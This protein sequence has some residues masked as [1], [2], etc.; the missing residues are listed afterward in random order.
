[1][2]HEYQT[3]VREITTPTLP[4]FVSACLNLIS[5]KQSSKAPDVPLS[6]EE[7]VSR[8]FAIL[9]PRH[10]TIFRPFVSQLR[11]VTRS[12]VAPTMSDD[13]FVSTSLKES[14]RRLVV[15]LHLT[16]AKNAGGEEWSKDVR[17]LVRD[18]HLTADC[19]FRAVIEDWESTA[20]YV[21][22]PV[23]LGLNGGG[24][25]NEDL[26]PWAGIY[27]G[28]ERLVGLLE[29]L[30]EYFRGGTSAPVTISLGRIMDMIT[31]LLSI[32]I[33][34]S[35]D[36]PSS[37]RGIRLNPAIDREERDGLWSGMPQIYVAAL[38][39]IG[40]IAERLEENFV[41]LA[42]SSFDQLV[43]VFPFGRHSPEFRLAAYDVAAKVLLR[44]GH[45][46][47]RGH[48]GKLALI[49]RSCCQDLVAVDPDFK[50]V[51]TTNVT[52][53]EGHGK[54]ISSNHN[55][56]SFLR[57]TVGIVTEVS[58]V[59]ENLVYGARELLPLF[60]SH[61]PQQFLDIS[62][63][64]LVERTAILSHNKNAM[65]ASILNPFVG[66]NGRAV[67]SILPHLTREFGGDDIVEIFLRPRMPLLR[68]TVTRFPLNDAVNS[69][70]V[71]DEYT[72]HHLEQVTIPDEITP[73]ITCSHQ[74]A[75][76]EQSRLGPA[77]TVPSSY[78]QPDQPIFGTY[79]PPLSIS[80][81]GDRSLGDGE[82]SVDH[83]LSLNTN[84]D[85]AMLEGDESSDDES[86]HLTMQLDTESDSDGE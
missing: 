76:P 4:T 27:A 24:K 64:S 36:T 72:H 78:N 79:A 55:A 45:S 69:E 6:L 62:L 25:G 20:G 38:Q 16:A 12:Y 47:G 84:Q 65:L 59:D 35:S 39:L 66:K 2:T 82:V 52:N 42:Q 34:P 37:S 77:L 3:L 1:M 48:A 86:V 49:I 17:N 73:S 32:A 14:A 71:E 8:S 53:K 10:T 18:I 44:I 50:N 68:A 63:R 81:F 7:S 28:V 19:V 26:P 9:L 67:T 61:Y 30:M 74:D 58:L 57:T 43:W 13:I 83:P 56:D 70:D 15:N 29:T 54:G 11:L 80:A 23:N 51:G 75:A 60:L 21:S 40:T 85:V 46:L 22:D 41:S 33:P 31:R 5:S